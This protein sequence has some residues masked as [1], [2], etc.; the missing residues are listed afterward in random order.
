[1]RIQE[2]ILEL[3]REL[4][5]ERWI[6]MRVGG[7]FLQNKKTDLGI[8]QGGVMSVTLFLVAINVILR[9]LGNEVDRSLFADDLTIYITTIN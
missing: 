6:K 4:I 2:K 8:P 5:S 9:K 7:F 3:I 1:M